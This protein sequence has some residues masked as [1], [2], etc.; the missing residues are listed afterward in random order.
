MGGVAP[1]VLQPGLSYLHITSSNDPQAITQSFATDS[2]FKISYLGPVGELKGEYIFQVEHAAGG[3]VKRDE[4]P[5]DIVASVKSVDGVRG[6][7]VLETKQRA[8]RDEF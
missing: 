3:T 4:L 8:K 2:N 1:P 5:S 7:K 6:A